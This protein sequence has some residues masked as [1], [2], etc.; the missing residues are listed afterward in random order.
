MKR[1]LLAALL[2]AAGTAQGQEVLK[3]GAVVTLSGPGAAWG[4]GMLYGAE[5]AADDVNAKGGLDVGGKKYRVELVAYDDKYQ[6]NEAVTAMN[7]LVYEDKVKFIIGP[8]G[9]APV[10]ALA[11]ITEKNK[12]LLMMLAFTSKALAPD[13]PFSFRPVLTSVETAQPMIDWVTKVAGAHKVGG[14]FVNDESGQQQYEYLSKAYQ[15]AGYPFAAYAYFERDR[16]DMVPLITGLM[17]KGVDAIELN[18]ISP[19][20]AGLIAK[21]ARELGFKGMFIRSG[22][23]ATAEIVAVAG[24]KAVEGMIV[25]TQFDP[26]N[27]AVKAYADRYQAKYKKTMNG[28]SP[29]FYDGTHML[30]RAISDAGTVSD[31]DKVRTALIDIKDYRGILGT[32]NW[33]GQ[34]IYGS[35]QQIDAPF[36]LSKVHDGKE[37]IAATCTLA[38]CR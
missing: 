14:L 13:K 19:A 28:F 37:A 34:A 8:T 22:G 36:F 29:S 16:V 38:A 2:C 10:L 11:P 25:Y 32:S 21:Q 17:A 12:V 26:G 27:P 33:T 24:P 9:S 4:Q 35:N 15:K 7:R 5:L 18:G 6:A 30:L 23:P 31:S 20:T 1:Y 3:L